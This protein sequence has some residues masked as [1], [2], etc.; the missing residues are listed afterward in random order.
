MAGVTAESVFATD[1][2]AR[3]MGMDL[4][5]AGPGTATVRMTVTD[6]MVNGHGT[7]HGG[8]LFTLADTAFACACNSHGPA[9]VAAHADI[10]FIAAARPG[11]E[12]EAVAVERAR[13]GRSG[14]Y[15]V[16]VHAGDRL[17][18]EFR[19]RSRVVRIPKESI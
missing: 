10:D 5:A 9:A 2:A 15:D 14:V 12:L 19:G 3:W 4:V 1:R 7:A 11:D 18:A 8:H 16:T 13:Y 17:I 6:D